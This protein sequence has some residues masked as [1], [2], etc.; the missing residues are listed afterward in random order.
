MTTR[1][2]ETYSDAAERLLAFGLRNRWYPVTPSWRVGAAPFGITRLG[3]KIVLWRDGAGE[4]RAIEDRCPH[5]G[6]RLSLGRN[7]GDRL[8][9]WYHGIEIDA[10]GRVLD[11]P[12]VESCPMVGET[13]LKSYPA[14]EVAGAIFLWFGDALHREPVPLALPEELTSDE[15]SRFLCTA[16]WKCNYRYALDNVIDPMHGTYLHMVSHSMAA[17]NKTARMR[18]RNTA[19]G[20][21]IEK[22]DQSGVNFDW[23]E[24]GDTGVQ[25]MRLVLPYRKSAGPGP[26]FGIVACATPV[27]DR[28]TYFSAW[29]VRKVVGWQRDLWR[30]M[31]RARFEGLHWD[32]LEQDRRVLESMAADASD[33]EFLYQHD[34]GIAR[35]RRMMAAEADTQVA[36]LASARVAAE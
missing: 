7:L 30:F 2:T 33:H 5:R 6:A 34:I 21:I 17:G 32:V 13:R 9:C 16:F 4:I 3:E 29:R 35:L 19:T 18:I 23:T 1:K 15:Q 11:V 28:V 25:W 31:Y 8:S 10:G 24:F 26:G 20:F 27:N 14:R 22:E 12:A 36:A